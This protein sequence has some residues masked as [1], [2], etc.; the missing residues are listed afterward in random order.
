MAKVKTYWDE[1][2]NDEFFLYGGNW[3]WEIH[4]EFVEDWRYNPKTGGRKEVRSL[5]PQWPFGYGS[6]KV[7]R[8]E[9]ALC[10]KEVMQQYKQ[11]KML[12]QASRNQ[13]ECR[14]LHR[15]IS[16]ENWEDIVAT[17]L[18]GFD[19]GS[20]IR[21]KYLTEREAYALFYNM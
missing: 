12:A 16:K 19:L 20:Y 8:E 18:R 7:P 11:R 10:K 21:S 5:K 13:E 14:D 1:I 15:R 2:K 17:G 4:F 6:E 9:K 3:G